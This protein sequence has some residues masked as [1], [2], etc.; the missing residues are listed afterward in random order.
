MIDNVFVGLLDEN[1]NE[2]NEVTDANHLYEGFL[3]SRKASKWKGSTQLFE[4]NFLRRISRLQKQLINRSYKIS[5]GSTFVLHERGKIRPIHAKT[6]DDRVVAHAFVDYVLMPIVRRYIIYDNCASIKGR[7]IDQQ[8]R[9]LEQ[10]LH[11]YY[12]TYGTNEGWILLGDFTKFYDNIQ[13]E[14]VYTLFEK[15]LDE[16]EL[17]LL[18]VFLDSFKVDVSYMDDDEFGKC[19]CEVFD[20]L[21]YWKNTAPTQKTG[22]KYM[23]KSI[24]IGDQTSQAIGVYY[25]T[26]IDNYI[27]IVKGM[28]WHGRYADDFYIISNSKQELEQILKEIIKIANEMG[29]FISIRKTYITKLK[30][31]FK[32]LQSHYWL[33]R[34]GAVVRKISAVR[35][36]AM[37]VKIKKLGEMIVKGARALS[38]IVNMVRSWIGGHAR[39]MSKLQYFSLKKQLI[40]LFGEEVVRNE[41][42]LSL[43]FAR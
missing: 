37:K 10:H 20:K 1:E 12:R 36:R 18:S 8:R 28:R 31:K 6:I 14:R 13:H 16:F 32:F 39:Y 23:N 34:S 4:L 19:L 35:V 40:D 38:D 26:R 17:W 25:P 21:I 9:R 5:A 42:N 2:Y 33:T 43:A 22:D 29:M 3:R 24:D 41:F 30:K 15:D 7:G 11:E 27:K